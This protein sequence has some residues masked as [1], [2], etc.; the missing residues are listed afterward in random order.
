MDQTTTNRNS[1]VEIEGSGGF[2]YEVAQGWEQ[3]PQGLRFGEV[4]GVA[5]DSNDRVYVFHRGEPP[6]IIFERDGTFVNSW[7]EGDFA[8]PHGIFI[9][10]DDAVY[11]TDD[12]D[13]TVRKF[14]TDGELLLTLGVSGQCSDT[15]V[16]NMDPGTVVRAGQPFNLPTNLGLSENGDM[17]I[18]DGYGNS[19][20]HKFSADGELLFSWGEPGNGPGQFVL[21]H[22]VAVDRNEK[23]YVAD[24]SNNRIQVFTANGEY[25]DEWTDTLSPCQLFIDADDYA[26]VAELPGRVSI[27]NL[28]GELQARWGSGS[29]ADIPG[30]F[31]G[32]HG[33]YLD[34]HGDLYV[35]EVG[36]LAES[37]N[38]HHLQKFIRIGN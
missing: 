19:R 38:R 34:V 37:P 5:V 22:G 31:Q 4:A 17:Y 23:V 15:G 30:D 3:L 9:G 32:A 25:L 18:S 2:R 1:E 21:P 28:D 10:S 29:G 26:Y 12:F 6:V 14:T 11:L 27:F 33:I 36:I 20:V 35:G 13:H 16:I 8:R 7:G 24:R